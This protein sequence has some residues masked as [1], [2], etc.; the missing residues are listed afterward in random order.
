M[1]YGEIIEEAFKEKGIEVTVVTDVIKGVGCYIDTWEHDKQ[2]VGKFLNEILDM[3]QTIID[4]DG[5]IHS[6]VKSEDLE[7]LR[8]GNELS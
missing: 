3:R 2:I 6:V 4:E 1:T 5:I 8:S 7:K